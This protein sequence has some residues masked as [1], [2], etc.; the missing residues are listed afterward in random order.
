MLRLHHALSKLQP[1]ANAEESN[2]PPIIIPKHNSPDRGIVDY[3]MIYIVGCALAPVVCVVYGCTQ[4]L[5]DDIGEKL[6]WLAACGV[7]CAAVLWFSPVLSVLSLAVLRRAASVSSL[8]RTLWAEVY[9]LLM[10][11]YPNPE[12]KIMNHGY[13]SDSEAGYTIEVKETEEFERYGYQMYHYLGTGMKELPHY[14]HLDVLEI[15]CGRGGGLAFLTKYLHPNSAT[16]VDSCERAIAFCKTQYSAVPGLNF[17]VGDSGNLP[18]ANQSADLVLDIG[19]SHCYP[20]FSRYLSEVVRVLRPEGRFLF[21]D[22]RPVGEVPDM[23]ATLR[24]SGLLMDKKEDISNSVQL[25]LKFDTLRRTKLVR[26]YTMRRKVQAALVA[27]ME[28]FAGVE[29]SH[30]YRTLQK[31]EVRYLAYKFTKA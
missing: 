31:G 13:A 17:L 3:I 10:W 29:T 12:W 2:S 14:R 18:L 28:E 27:A 11:L 23:E 5:G 9:D 21:A 25:A 26:A 7:L 30:F 22:F 8:R 20:N 15:S 19:N 1:K 16:G 6:P 4:L 24:S